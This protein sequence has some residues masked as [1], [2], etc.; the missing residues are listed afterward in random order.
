MCSRM[1]RGVPAV[2]NV[3]EIIKELAEKL[4]RQI[5]IDDLSK[6]ESM[7]ELKEFIE[8]LWAKNG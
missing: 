3:I 2:L 4:E 5:I 1:G 6:M 8:K 7:G